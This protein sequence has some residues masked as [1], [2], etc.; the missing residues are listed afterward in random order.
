MLRLRQI[1]LYLGVF[2]APAIIFFAFSGALQTLGLHENHDRAGPPPPAWIAAI[3]GMHKH[4][5]LPD[6]KK[7]HAA[8]PP[9]ADRHDGINGAKDVNGA[10]G[11]DHD[12]DTHEHRPE[13]ST[14][15]LKLFV[16]ALAIGLIVS[17]LTGIYIALSNPRTRKGAVAAFAIGLLLPAGLL[18][19]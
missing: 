14:W 9:A 8:R 6:P 16:L 15:P 2:F 4:Q 18:Y 17:A 10:N 5:R 13:K 1:H 3:A 7:A 19:L 11:A 12:N